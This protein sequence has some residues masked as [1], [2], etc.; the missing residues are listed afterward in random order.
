M[1][2]YLNLLE[3][4]FKPELD[5]INCFQNLF[6]VLHLY[7]Q[8]AVMK[9]ENVVESHTK[10]EKIAHLFKNTVQIPPGIIVRKPALAGYSEAFKQK[11]SLLY[12][13]AAIAMLL[14]NASS[15]D[16]FSVYV[17]AYKIKQSQNNQF[18]SIAAT[19]IKISQLK[20]Y[21]YNCGKKRHIRKTCTLLQNCKNKTNRKKSAFKQEKAQSC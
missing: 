3:R 20:P 12:L 5:K 10:L 1:V 18:K 11:A 16:L 6:Q 21:C 17:K 9:R 8:D 2:V 13:C 14:R 7:L 4:Q 15:M 19:I